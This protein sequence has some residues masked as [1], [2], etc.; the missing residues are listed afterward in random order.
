M[1]GVLIA[2]CMFS[3]V[4]GSA[5]QCPEQIQYNSG[6][7]LKSGDRFYFNNSEDFI[8][9]QIVYYPGRRF[10]KVQNGTVYYPNGATLRSPIGTFY[11]PDGKTLKF[12]NTGLYYQNGKKLNTK[13]IL[14]AE[15]F[16]D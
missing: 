7:Y 15:R 9:G 11:Y 8:S 5:S 6:L 2:V 12:T 13:E 4:V 14:S 1:K 16:Y 10:F 3:S